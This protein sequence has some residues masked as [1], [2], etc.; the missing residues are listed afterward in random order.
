MPCIAGAPAR[1]MAAVNGLGCALFGC[2]LFGCAL[3][4]CAE[5]GQDR[6]SI[7]LYVAGTELPA[8]LASAGGVPIAVERA[9]LAFGPLYLCAGATAGDLCDTARLEWLGTGVV[10]LAVAAPVRVGELEGITGPVRSWMFDLGISSQLTRA[11]PFVLEASATLG[12]ASIVIEGSAMLAGVALPLSVAIPIAQSEDTELGV[13][14]IR[15]STNEPF[16]HEVSAGE[17]GLLVRFDARPWLEALDLRELVE[18][19]ACAAGGPALAC[20]GP[21]EQ[22]CAPDGSVTSSRD[23]ASSGLSCIARVGCAA[24][25]DIAPDTRAFRSLRNALVS[26]GRPT[27][28]WGFLP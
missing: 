5:T 2:A 13:P 18:D 10:D 15:K 4:G 27:F 24:E 16:S 14:V 6:V 3:F 1:A 26:G 20:A 7:P 23:C 9:E 21:V 22:S 12:G 11:E 17:A 19:V 8:S 28:E 25:V